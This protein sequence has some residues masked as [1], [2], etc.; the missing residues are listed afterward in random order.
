MHGNHGNHGNHNNH[1][2]HGNHRAAR[3]DLVAAAHAAMIEHGFQPDFPVGTDKQLAEINTQPA[4]PENGFK[5]LRNLLWSSIDNDTSKD[6]DQ[7][8]WAE[9]LPDGRIR[10]LVG[11]ATSSARAAG[12]VI[13]GHAQS[14]TTSVYAGVKVFP[15]LPTELSEGV[16]SLNENQDRAAI[17]IE[18]CVDA[19]EL[20]QRQSL[21]RSG[22]QPRATCLPERGR[23][24]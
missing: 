10:V 3:F 14:E 1:G 2:N 16:T 4:L 11:V 18:M 13:D 7:I 9:Q 20:Q 22:P 23:M 24:A 15:M 21:P 19:G 8:E 17:V 5:D 6:L 12:T